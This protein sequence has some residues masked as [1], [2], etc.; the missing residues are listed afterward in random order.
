MSYPTPQTSQIQG[1]N[2]SMRIH[3]EYYDD[4]LSP[5]K[6]YSDNKASRVQ[7]M[8]PQQINYSSRSSQ[9]SKTVNGPYMKL[10]D[11]ILMISRLE[12]DFQVLMRQLLDQEEVS[13]DDLLLIRELLASQKNKFDL[14]KSQSGKKSQKNQQQV[15]RPASSLLYEKQAQQIGRSFQNANKKGQGKFAP[16]L[17]KGS[18]EKL[19]NQKANYTQPKSNQN[20]KSEISLSTRTFDVSKNEPLRNKVVEKAK[21]DQEAGT[22][23]IEIV[24]KNQQEISPVKNGNAQEQIQIIQQLPDQDNLGQAQEFQVK[25]KMYGVQSK[26]KKL[27]AKQNDENKKYTKQIDLIFNRPVPQSQNVN[28]C[29]LFIFDVA[30]CISKKTHKL[31]NWTELQTYLNSIGKEEAIQEIKQVQTNGA[32]LTI[33]DKA[34]IKSL[35]PCF[36][37]DNTDLIYSILSDIYGDISSKDDNNV[38]PGSIVVNKRSPGKQ[39]SLLKKVEVEYEEINAYQGFE[40]RKLDSLV[41]NESIIWQSDQLKIAPIYIKAKA[42]EGLTGS[43]ILIEKRTERKAQESESPKI[44]VKVQNKS[45][46]LNQDKQT[47]LQSSRSQNQLY[48]Q[49][50]PLA[51]Y[52]NPVLEKKTQEIQSEFMEILSEMERRRNSRGDPQAFYQGVSDFYREGS[53]SHN[54]PTRRLIDHK[55]T[56]VDHQQSI[57]ERDDLRLSNQKQQFTYTTSPNKTYI[58][59]PHGES[60]SYSMV[61]KDPTKF[62]ERFLNQ[63]V[64]Q[65]KIQS[66]RE[67]N[68][69]QSLNQRP[70][71]SITTKITKRPQN[72]IIEHIKEKIANRI[73]EKIGNQIAYDQIKNIISDQVYDDQINQLIK[74][75]KIKLQNRN[76]SPNSNLSSKN[77]NSRPQSRTSSNI[78]CINQQNG[79]Q[80]MR[81]SALPIK[82]KNND[83][84]TI[85]DITI[86][87]FELQM[88]Q[89]SV[90]RS[91]KSTISSSNKKHQL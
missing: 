89:K 75:D 84:Q 68:N 5:T 77:P 14:R 60:V 85:D 48:T 19:V 27:D 44:Q 71:S 87:D 9:I 53:E 31:N 39:M 41:Q 47:V 64:T 76:K 36:Q 81:R 73:F 65:H 15:Q 7:N 51:A 16:V 67:T 12:S 35:Y 56:K 37:E 78:D 55:N 45:Q 17:N 1:A 61:K 54:S 43:I 59:E 74:N 6:G 18:N 42:D 90:L 62:Y 80:N 21:Q 38:K 8:T 58:V 20:P 13:N 83:S 30:K 26:N 46:Q 29:C 11:K 52:Y 33:V 70:K 3:S 57:K 34:R 2:S 40:K 22:R 63:D 50:E 69:R 32:K 28:N 79:L 23:N 25:K 49:E 66:F 10:E 72:K 86:D 88:L 24:N 4:D 82:N 91:H